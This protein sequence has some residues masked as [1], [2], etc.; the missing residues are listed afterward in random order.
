MST[1]EQPSARKDKS[2]QSELG[3]SSSSLGLGIQLAG[4]ML[5][6]VIIGYFVDKWLD[7][8][9]WFIVIGSIVGMVAFFFQ[10]A[11][12]AKRMSRSSE[13]HGAGDE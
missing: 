9:P 1:N 12:I 3:R 5:V 4:S 8:A 10:L 6:Y 2:W 13:N 7:T 11:R